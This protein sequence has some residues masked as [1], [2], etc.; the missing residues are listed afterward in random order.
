M[1]LLISLQ[2][3]KVPFSLLHQVRDVVLVLLTQILHQQCH[4]ACVQ[5][6]VTKEGPTWS[7]SFAVLHFG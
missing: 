3:R 1:H 5:D 4:M 2:I 6:I 7:N